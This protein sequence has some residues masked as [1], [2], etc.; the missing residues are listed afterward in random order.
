[1]ALRRRNAPILV[2]GA[3]L[4]MAT[5]VLVLAQW[6]VTFFQ[7]TFAFLLD[8]QPWTPHS[9]L[10]PHNEHIVVLPVLITKVLLEVF[11]MTS[12]VPEQIAMG[13]TLVAVA[14]LLFVWVRRRVGPWLALV[15]AATIL[16]LG[17]AWPVILWPFENE[18]TL[19]IVFGLAMLLFL[20]REDSRGDA[21]ACAMLVL[22]TISGSLGISFIVAAFVDLVL[23]RRERGW[24]RAYVFAVPLL[25]YLAWYA[26][27]GHEAEH[28]LT[29]HNILNSPAYVVE[30]F[31]SALDS[32]AGLST[33]P[34]NSPG[35]N[36][37]GR[38][39]LVG[40]VALVAFGQWRKPG[41][42][43][44]FWTVAIAAVSYWLLAALNFVPGREASA[45]RYV[46]A[47]A[48]FVLLM[49]AELL[50]GWRFSQKALIIVGAAALLAI[51][52][53]LAQMKNGSD[54]EKEQ[55]IYTRS[56]IAAMEIARD[57]VAPTFYLGSVETTGTASLSL[58][59]A[60]KWFEAI[61]RWGTPAYSVPELERAS[62]IGRHFADLVLSQALPISVEST[63]GSFDSSR[64]A[65]ES[66]FPLPGGES[67]Q[68][69]VKIGPG[70][71]RVE[72]APGPPAT[73]AMRRFAS[74]E[75]PVPIAGGE[76][77]ST[78]VVTVPRDRAKNPWYIH[79][80]A[81]Q[82]TRVCR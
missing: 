14:V 49:A 16:F 31:A 61:D 78:T 19:P 5:I 30:G 53:N 77:D 67:A 38:P 64:S 13:A 59:E 47:G 46:Y 79:V 80:E 18:F 76:G 50:R 66:C 73:I 32:L 42:S 7:D 54:W 12:N 1:M 25:V 28:H 21:W 3:A 52:P 72:V 55:S 34:V 48:V 74:A 4:A 68:T 22:A 11:G 70:L 40:A 60:E 10:M 56:D 43:R 71:T 62:P 75:F 17:S 37:W 81:S 57:T 23:N 58:V 6:H 51:L 27:Y 29:L 45:S 24:R 20:D 41:F 15:A 82:L 36:D 69:E 26:G 35:Q 65:A 2:F 44:G 8:R 33:I 9:F 39:L 63:P